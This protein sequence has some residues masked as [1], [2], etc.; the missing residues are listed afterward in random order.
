MS[1]FGILREDREPRG[2]SIS[3]VRKDDVPVSF[4]TMIEAQ[5]AAR[6][7]RAGKKTS[8]RAER[9]TRRGRG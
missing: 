1:K 8:Y 7:L 9:F 6:R 2:M 3:W 4:E 5:E